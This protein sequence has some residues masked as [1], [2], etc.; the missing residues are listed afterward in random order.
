MEY[1]FSENAPKAIGPYSQAVKVKDTLYLSGVMPINP[2]TNSLVE[3]DITTQANQVIKNIDAI[4]K[5]A[6]MDANNVVKTTCFISD[7]EYF[8]AFNEVYAKYFVSKPARSCVAVKSLPKN[9]LIEIEVI[10]IQ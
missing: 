7:M 10:A 2:E 3:S 8:A 9:A 6:G 1:I 5:E 4:L